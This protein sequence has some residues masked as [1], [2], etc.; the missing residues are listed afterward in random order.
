MDIKDAISAAFD[1]HT[2]KE[3]VKEDVQEEKEEEKL[4]EGKEQEAAEPKEEE[5]PK[6]EKEE[7][8]EEEEKPDEPEAKK[9]D[10]ESDEEEQPVVQGPKPPQSWK[11]EVRAHWSKLPAEVQ[12]EVTRREVEISRTLTNT[13]NARRLAAEFTRIVQPYE[14][15]I[16]MQ[17]STPLQTVSNMMQTAAVLQMG[18]PA[19]KAKAV[20]EVIR[21]FGVDI[22][23]LDKLLANQN[24]DDPTGTI[25][26][27]INQHLAPV[28]KLLERLT[29]QDQ[30]RIKSE[31]ERIAG[32]ID[33]FAADPKNAYFEDLREDIADLIDLAEKRGRK[34]SLRAAYDTALAQRPDLAKLVSN[35]AAM[36]GQ[37]K[38]ISRKKLEKAKAAASSISGS[39]APAAGKPKPGN[40]RSAIEDAW[41]KASTR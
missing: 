37:S 3:E 35:G 36:N 24:V 40:V 38:S 14:G 5:E 10:D 28:N 32:E 20:V 4:L 26:S 39:S 17:K 12:A 21:S 15:L 6:A 7:P 41:D 33:A 16:R 9:D 19:Q 22:E 11:P 2:E 27:R 13:T 1:E 8:K 25:D 30:A 23:T 34:L 29:E 18:T 31:E